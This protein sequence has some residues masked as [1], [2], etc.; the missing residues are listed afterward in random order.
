MKKVLQLLKY[1]FGSIEHKCPNCKTELETWIKKGYSPSSLGPFEY[2]CK[3]C[4][5]KEEDDLGGY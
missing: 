3:T 5:Y 2:R 4:N 1:I